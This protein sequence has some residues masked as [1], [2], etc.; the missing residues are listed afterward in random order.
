MGQQADCRHSGQ[1]YVPDTHYGKHDDLLQ[2]RR[3]PP[4]V[5][6]ILST[7]SI[8]I[9]Q[10]MCL[11]KRIQPHRLSDGTRCDRCQGMERSRS[12]A[13]AAGMRSPAAPTAAT[14]KH[15]IWIRNEQD[16]DGE[17]DCP[18]DLIHR[19]TSVARRHTTTLPQRTPASHI[20]ATRANK[21]KKGNL[22]LGQIPFKYCDGAE[23][24]IYTR[25]GGFRFPVR[26]P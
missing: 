9:C 15:R 23:G 8:R 7:W 26:R 11:L 5:C 1:R 14:G 10:G 24:G 12:R 3:L 13:A 4:Q 21:A 17:G 2:E 20:R 22:A 16:Q 25:T 6:T 19:V 18:R